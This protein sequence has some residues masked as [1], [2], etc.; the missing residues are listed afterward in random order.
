M[1]PG[2]MVIEPK[3][4]PWLKLAWDFF[5]VLLLM[6]I[7]V[8]LYGSSTRAAYWQAAALRAQA[9]LRAEGEA[10]PAPKLAEVCPAWWFGSKDLAAARSRL[11]K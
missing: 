4:R 1:K 6:Y 11:C 10:C 2:D 3:Y 5:I 8:A 7:S 9:Q